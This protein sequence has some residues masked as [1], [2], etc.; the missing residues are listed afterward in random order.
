[1][2]DAVGTPDVDGLGVTANLLCGTT[3]VRCKSEEHCEDTSVDDV[4]D[5]AVCRVCKVV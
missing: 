4:S 2:G 1:M 5:S 3:G